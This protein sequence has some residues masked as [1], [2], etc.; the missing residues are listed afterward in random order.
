[1]LMVSFRHRGVL[2]DGTF[3]CCGAPLECTGRLFVRHANGSS[4]GSVRTLTIF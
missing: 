2:A 1:M 4:T 3:A